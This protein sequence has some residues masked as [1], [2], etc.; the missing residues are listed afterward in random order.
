MRNQAV[1]TDSIFFKLPRFWGTH[2]ASRPDFLPSLCLVSRQLYQEATLEFI[3][4]SSFLLCDPISTEFMLDWLENLGSEYKDKG[5]GFKSV[6]SLNFYHFIGCEDTSVRPA[7]RD[8]ELIER[9]ANLRDLYLTFR[10][11][12]DDVISFPPQ[13]FHSPSQP[14]PVYDPASPPFPAGEVP[15]LYEGSAAEE[16]IARHRLYRVLELP[17]L[18]TFKFYF[19]DSYYGFVHRYQG[20]NDLL[21]WLK[22][23]FIQRERN[24]AVTRMHKLSHTEGAAAWCSGVESMEGT[25]HNDGGASEDGKSSHD[26]KISNDR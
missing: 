1:Q 11:E 18:E 15:P 3:K 20:P 21:D 5:E 2:S 14:D 7:W 12:E 16:L 8:W 22:G 6:R 19:A 13:G 4:S 17:H 23:Q 24:A 26:R 9:C 25:A 10:E